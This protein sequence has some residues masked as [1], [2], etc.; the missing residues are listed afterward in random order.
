[1]HYPIELL[2]YSDFRFWWGFLLFWFAILFSMTIPGNILVHKLKLGWWQNITLSTSAGLALWILQGYI[3]GMLQVRYLSYVYVLACVIFWLIR[4]KTLLPTFSFRFTRVSLLMLGLILLATLIETVIVFVGVQ[5]R[6]GSLSFATYNQVGE[7]GHLYQ[8]LKQMP[9]FTPGMS[10]IYIQNYHYFSHLVIADL[11]RVFDLPFIYTLTHYFVPFMTI[12]YG[13]H[14][15]LLA[16]ILQLNNSY[17]VWILFFAYFSQN[18]PSVGANLTTSLSLPQIFSALSLLVLWLRAPTRIVSFLIIIVIATSVGIKAHTGIF[19]CMGVAFIGYWFVLQKKFVRIPTLI[20]TIVLSLAL[21]LPTNHGSGGIHFAGFWHGKTLLEKISSQLNP[22]ISQIL[23]QSVH[24]VTR[25][26]KV[27]FH[28]GFFMLGSVIGP[29]LYCIFLVTYFLLR[30]FWIF[31]TRYSMGK[32][33][34]E[35]HIFLIPSILISIFIGTTFL[36]DSGGDH[37][38][39]FILIAMYAVL[40]YCAS[41]F[42]YGMKQKP[43]LLRFGFYIIIGLFT[44]NRIYSHIVNWNEYIFIRP[45][46]I[47][48]LEF[49]ALHYLKNYANINYLTIVDPINK[50]DEVEAYVGLFSQHPMYY[51]QRFSTEAHGY[52]QASERSRVYFQFFQSAQPDTYVRLA[53]ANKIKYIYLNSNSNYPIIENSTI[54]SRVFSNSEVSIYEI[55]YPMGKKL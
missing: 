51:S 44:L 27:D 26:G 1:M 13:A 15:L 21:Y 7:L 9:P 8:L 47:S 42:S 48:S 45:N 49:E 19:L 17:K 5:T 28:L 39:V 10:G 14:I 53:M 22:Q 6:D 38:S 30:S 12:M 43:F 3:F 25:F 11:V 34:I 50:L 23:E 54:A 20:L 2:T 16:N 41:A 32:F 55:I 31:Q 36:Q 40:P 52:P 4:C 18:Y 33:P 29:L 37:S 46:H 24:N 35:F